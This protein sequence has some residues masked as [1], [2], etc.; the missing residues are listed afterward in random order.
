MLIRWL[1]TDMKVGLMHYKHAISQ[2]CEYS[3]GYWCLLKPHVSRARC[4]PE[5]I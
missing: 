1:K 3:V 5:E 4:V 2:S